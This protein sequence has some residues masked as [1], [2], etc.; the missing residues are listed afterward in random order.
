M[1]T[2]SSTLFNSRQI[3]WSARCGSGNDW[4]M[5]GSA[6]LLHPPFLF[7]AFFLDF[8]LNVVIVEYV[9]RIACHV[10]HA[11]DFVLPVVLRVVEHL[12]EFVLLH[13]QHKHGS[14]I[15]PQKTG[16]RVKAGS[17]NK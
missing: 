17:T 9:D 14:L 13:L 12:A 5:R 3:F 2:S 6:E 16:T 1:E 11:E 10:L 7:A 8:G 15:L 4:R